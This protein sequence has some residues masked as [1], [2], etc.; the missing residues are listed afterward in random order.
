[1]CVLFSWL[2][3]SNQLGAMLQ[4]VVP[5]GSTSNGSRDNSCTGKKSTKFVSALLVALLAGLVVAAAMTK[6]TSMLSDEATVTHNVTLHVEKLDQPDDK[7]DLPLDVKQHDV[8]TVYQLAQ[9]NN[10]S[11]AIHPV[12][13]ADESCDAIIHQVPS[14]IRVSVLEEVDFEEGELAMT[15]EVAG[16]LLE[17]HCN[18]HD[19]GCGV[20]D[21]G[22]LAGRKLRQL[23]WS[24]RR[25]RR[26]RRAP[27]PTPAPT[28][29]I[30]LA[31]R[32][33]Q[34]SDEHNEWIAAA[35]VRDTTSGRMCFAEVVHGCQNRVYQNS[36][37]WITADLQN[38]TSNASDI[39]DPFELVSLPGSA[40]KAP[41]PVQLVSHGNFSAFWRGRGSWSKLHIKLLNIDCAPAMVMTADPGEELGCLSMNASV[42]IELFNGSMGNGS[43]LDPLPYL[44]QQNVLLGLVHVQST[45]F[46]KVVSWPLAPPV[47]Y[48]SEISFNP[49]SA[50]LNQDTITVHDGMGKLFWHLDSSARADTELRGAHNLQRR[51]IH[52]RFQCTAAI[53]C[54]TQCT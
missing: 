6:V 17:V 43:L 51:A 44:C 22:V 46:R 33:R 23:W 30:P 8:I 24:R 20:E 26:R 52:H 34:G 18:P 21:H 28:A 19:S 48:I 54:P 11:V 31:P 35:S 7:G 47:G 42:R 41:F 2:G 4:Q 16:R 13:C 27:P 14:K 37:M 29:K 1:M 36:G 15:T 10:G 40:I 25:R 49:F 38:D 3:H 50:V 32:L 39:Q 9:Q 45:G 5:C 12:V 53:T